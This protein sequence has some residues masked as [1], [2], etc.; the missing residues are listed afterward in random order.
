[1]RMQVF[2]VNLDRYKEDQI[3]GSWFEP[4]ID[5]EEMKERIGLDGKYKEYAIFDYDLPFEIDEST[6]VSDINRICGAIG[7]IEGS[8]LYDALSEVQRHWFGSIEE[9]LENID[10]IMYYPD[11][12]NMTDVARV[13]IEETVDIPSHLQ[14]YMNYEVYG[15]DLDSTG[16]FVMT[17]RGIFKYKQ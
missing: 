16:N 17:S 5:L 11:S 1:M 6:P 2:I 7:E 3:R 13:F 14:K 4:P 15:R 12:E 10:N 9:L 8:P